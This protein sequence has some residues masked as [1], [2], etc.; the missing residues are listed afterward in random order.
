MNAQL[1]GPN[2][3]M[4]LKHFKNKTTKLLVMES[5]FTKFQIQFK[6]SKNLIRNGHRLSLKLKNGIKKLHFCNNLL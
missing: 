2:K 1:K 3:K 4:V 6:Y 5:I